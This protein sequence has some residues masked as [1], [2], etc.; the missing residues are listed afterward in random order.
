MAL[1]LAEIE[2]AALE[3]RA[4]GSR[5]GK[6]AR[7][8]RGRAG[9]LREGLRALLLNFLLPAGIAIREEQERRAGREL[10]ALKEHRGGGREQQQ[11][12]HG[13]QLGAA[14]QA[15]EPLARD[16]IGDLVVVLQ[17]HDELL[18]AKI[19]SRL[20]ARLL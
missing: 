12:R 8:R 16:L 20:P 5:R 9:R 7:L 18:G 2:L 1:A 4:L 13:A 15:V 14:S 10:L 19:Q 17:V 6:R 11:R 3:R